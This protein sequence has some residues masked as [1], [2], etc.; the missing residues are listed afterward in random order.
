MRWK[1]G[2]V[3][4]AVL[5][6]VAVV[7]AVRAEGPVP[8]GTVVAVTGTVE[9]GAGGV[10]QP[11]AAKA[12]LFEGQAIRTSGASGV[13]V[14]FGADVPAKLGEKTEILVA[15]LMLKAQ[16]E[17][18]KAKIGAPADATKVEMQVTPLTGVRGTE[19]TEEKAGELKRD[20]YWNESAPAAK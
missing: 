7:P 8:V 6:A 2:V 14:L 3:L 13:E 9:I 19:K 10:W 1:A 11:A 12:Q 4:A 5:A 15:D 16:L 18:A 17:K 20:H